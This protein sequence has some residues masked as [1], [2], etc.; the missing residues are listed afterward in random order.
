M[1]LHLITLYHIACNE[2]GLGKA[3]WTYDYSKSKWYEYE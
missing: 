1:T 3:I 2:N